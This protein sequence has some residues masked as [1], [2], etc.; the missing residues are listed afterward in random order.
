MTI[1]GRPR[2]IL[3]CH[4][5]ADAGQAN[6]TDESQQ[7]SA[8]IQMAE[9]TDHGKL[10]ADWPMGSSLLSRLGVV[11]LKGL[12]RSTREHRQGF[13]HEKFCHPAK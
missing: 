5:R 2:W 3:R 8:G 1:A 13:G 4:E 10:L 7:G 11:I 9:T 6:R 12:E